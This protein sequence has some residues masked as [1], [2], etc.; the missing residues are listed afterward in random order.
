MEDCVF[1]SPYNVP[2]SHSPVTISLWEV[3]VDGLDCGA[4]PAKW[5]SR[6]LGGDQEFLLIQHS[7]DG[8][9]KRKARNKYLK[10][11]PRTFPTSCIPGFA[12]VTP[13]MMTTQPSL[14]DLRSRLPGDVASQVTQRT[15]RPNIVI[16]GENLQPWQEDRWVGEVMIGETIFKYNRDCTRC[17]ATTV[18]KI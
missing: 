15:F 8:K 16:G 10:T 12:D 3:E 5:L 18:L 9:S 6:F 4:G 7:P 11:Y 13:Y 2:D 14:L 17:I 1:Q